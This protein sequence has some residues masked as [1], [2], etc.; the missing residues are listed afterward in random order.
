MV[1]DARRSDQVR[2]FSKGGQN[3]LGLLRGDEPAAPAN[4]LADAMEKQGETLHHAATQDNHV[5]DKQIDEIGETQTQ[6][7]RL[8]L[9]DSAS[10]RIPMFCQFADFSR[11][12]FAIRVRVCLLGKPRGHCWSCCQSFPTTSE[13]ARTQ[14]TGS[15]QN[16]VA[17]L[18]M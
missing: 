1:P 6:I 11:G 17:D 5:R 9:D 2:F 7:V 15:I 8:A 4:R 12:A 10:D 18:R 3:D 16:V 13:T 14:R